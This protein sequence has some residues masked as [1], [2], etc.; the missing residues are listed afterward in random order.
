MDAVLQSGLRSA[1]PRTA[2]SSTAPGAPRPHSPADGALQRALARRDRGESP[3]SSPA[4]RTSG[5]KGRRGLRVGRTPTRAVPEVG[6]RSSARSGVL[7]KVV[8]VLPIDTAE[9]ARRLKAR[10][11]LEPTSDW[12]S[13]A[14]AGS[15]TRTRRPRSRWTA[16]SIRALASEALRAPESWALVLLEPQGA[17]DQAAGSI[18]AARADDAGLARAP[19]LIA[20]FEGRA[21][22]RTLA[23]SSAAPT[24]S[25]RAASIARADVQG[26]DEFARLGRAFNE[27]ADQLEARMTRA[28][29]GASAAA[30]GDDALRR[31]ARGDARHG[32]A[33]PYPRRDR[34][35]RDGRHA[36]APCAET[37]ARSSA[38]ATRRRGA[39]GSSST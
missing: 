37:T 34:D 20:Y 32:R 39:D 16:R 3:R 27:M 6:A 38:R 31:S 36:A 1:S 7:G 35:R 13:S 30:R 28:G 22:V 18:G 15:A 2:R 14:Q 19:V 10:A 17:I 21:I 33:A 24:T 25:P 8:A 23:G 11:G 12:P 4:C 29:R 9:L 26:P 5:S